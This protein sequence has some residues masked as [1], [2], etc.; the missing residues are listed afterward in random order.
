MAAT[1]LLKAP[2]V[3]VAEISAAEA[4]ALEAVRREE[5]AR[6]AAERRAA[7]EAGRQAAAE[8]A[9]A[10]VPALVGAVDR[11]AALLPELVSREATAQA[12]RLTALVLEAARWVVQREL[13]TEPDIVVRRLEAV[14]GHLLPTGRLVVSVSPGAVALVEE[15][16]AGRDADVVADPSLGDGEARLE[17]GEASADLS[18]EV[19]FERLREVLGA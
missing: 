4:A 19:A 15:W 12:E 10:A 13:A 3:R 11:A 5:E 16:L 18:L 17:A 8:E 2:R 6:R 7:Y 14:L 1:R 9:L